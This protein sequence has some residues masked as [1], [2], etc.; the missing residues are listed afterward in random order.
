MTQ[1]LLSVA[2]RARSGK[3][4]VVDA[5]MVDGAAYVALPILKWLQSG[6]MPKGD[7]L[8]SLA[9]YCLTLCSLAV[10]DAHSVG[11]IFIHSRAVNAHSVGAMLDQYGHLDATNSVLNQVLLQSLHLSSPHM[12]IAGSNLSPTLWEPSAEATDCTSRALSVHRCFPPPVT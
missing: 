5:A 10:A 8:W 1:V 11:A 3:G 2:E 7:H 12:H 9:I 4:Q 6:F